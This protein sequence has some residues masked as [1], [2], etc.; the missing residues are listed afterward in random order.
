MCISWKGIVGAAGAGVLAMVGAA[1]AQL[2]LQPLTSFGDNGYLVTGDYPFLTADH[3]QRGLAYNPLTNNLLLVDRGIADRGGLAVHRI[4]GLTGA[5]L[6]GTLN[7]AGV[8]G[9]HV[10]DFPGNV[11]RV[12]DDGVIYMSNL[13]VNSGT[14]NLRIWRWENEAAA[15]IT[16]PTLVYDGNPRGG[17]DNMRLGD[18]FDVR[19]SGV[20]TQFIMGTRHSPAPGD[21]RAVVFN[22][23]DGVNFTPTLLHNA[24]IPGQAA[25]L[26]AT[27]GEGN[28]FYANTPGGTALVYH[29]SFDPA[30]GAITVLHSAAKGDGQNFTQASMSAIGYNAEFDALVGVVTGGFVNHWA[31]LYDISDFSNA[32]LL[33]DDLLPNAGDPN[34]AGMEQGFTNGNATAAVAFGPDG[35]TY[36][37]I[38]NVGI[39]AYVIPEPASIGLLGIAGL[40]LMARRRK[41]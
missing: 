17:T 40:G 31:Q 25:Y 13:V 4:D 8:S 1:Q 36:V 16:P 33:D 23:T 28:T 11:I 34:I 20:N 21:N 15:L 30:T 18:T 22:T 29:L 3:R 9:G 19:G 32:L 2:Q 26:G 35:R 12:A 10:G 7:V 24:D 38:T 27:W 41:A 6:P 5:V 14:D 37:L 39:A